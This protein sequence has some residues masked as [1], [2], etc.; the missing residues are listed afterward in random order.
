[1]FN[2]Q[3]LRG[4][5]GEFF[6]QIE[7]YHKSLDDISSDIKN[8]E[9]VLVKS[10][11]EDFFLYISDDRIMYF[12]DSRIKYS[13]IDQENPKPLIECKSDIRIN[14]YH[15][16]PIFFKYAIGIISRYNET[17]LSIRGKECSPN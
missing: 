10:G 7:H 6:E 4:L 13:D 8:L 11:V 16:L 1:M 14:V 9:K 5:E 17:Y 3:Y 15:F 12:E 2:N